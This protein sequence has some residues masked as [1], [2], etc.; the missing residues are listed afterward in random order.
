METWTEKYSH[1][2]K[3][4]TFL[5][6]FT[7]EQQILFLHFYIFLTC[8][9]AEPFFF[10]LH[11]MCLFLSCSFEYFN[12]RLI[13]FFKKSIKNKYILL[14]CMVKTKMSMNIC[15]L[16]RFSESNNGISLSSTVQEGERSIKS[17]VLDLG[18]LFR[19]GMLRKMDGKCLLA[20]LSPKH[21]MKSKDS[22]RRFQLH[23]QMT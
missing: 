8:H 12:C 7:Q 16:Q 11:L 21:E 9:V 19:L 23:Q 15:F 4:L 13:C 1:I 2:G 20:V 10:H 18:L 6:H 17:T 14:S 5:Q 3:V 22:Q